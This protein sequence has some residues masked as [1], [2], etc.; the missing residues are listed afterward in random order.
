MKIELKKLEKITGYKIKK[1]FTAIGFDTAKRT[2]VCQI[3]TNGKCAD[4]DWTF[5]EF[6]DKIEHTYYKNMVQFFEG[7]LINQDLAIIESTFVGQNVMGSIS[8]TRLGAFGI[9]EAIRKK[10]PWER[11][12]A[13]SARS[14]LKIDARKFGKGKSKESVAYW[15]ETQLGIKLDDPDISDAIVLCLLGI[16]EG[17]DF[18]SQADIAE[19]KRNAKSKIKNKR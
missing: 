4:L 6:D 1:D 13:S 14:K 10:I 7:S 8:L 12:G 17:M 18:R 15:L 5:V 9:S 2:G 3:K 16:C 19:A 11:I